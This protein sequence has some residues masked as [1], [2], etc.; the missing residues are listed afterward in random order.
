M[1]IL[2]IR[3]HNIAS[4]ADEFHL[5]LESG[6]LGAAGLFA[7]TGPTGS[8][9]STLLD[10]MCLA[11]YDKTPRFSESGGALVGTHGQD[12][13]LR[14]KAND[15]RTMLRR[16]S[17]SG[18]AEVEFTG[19]DQG[20]Y[21]AR[22]EVRRARD[23]AQG[24]L[25]PQSMT[26]E[27]V[28]TGELVSGNRSAVRASIEEKIGLTFGQFRRSVMLA[29]GD[30]AAFLKAKSGQ[31]AALLE[32]MTGTSIYSHL[33]QK[34]Y[35]RCK[36]EGGI[37]AE[38]N[39]KLHAL[40]IKT[41]EE[42]EQLAGRLAELEEELKSLRKS[43]EGLEETLRWYE[44][45]VR[46]Q[47]EVEEGTASLADAAAAFE[48]A[49]P[50]REE[51]A[52]IEA[53]QPLRPRLDT[54]GE[55]E[56]ATESALTRLDTAQHALEKCRRMADQ[57]EAR[58][59][60]SRAAGQEVRRERDDS[61]PELD[62]AKSLDTRLEESQSR[63]DEANEAADGT[64]E[65]WKQA[66]RLSAEL[67]ARVDAAETG[68]TEARRWLEEQASLDKVAR[69]WEPCEK[70]L[71]QYERA[72]AAHLAAQSDLLRL[73]KT[74]GATEKELDA[75]RARLVSAQAG[76]E[77]LDRAVT[78][79]EA[80]AGQVSGSEL[81]E[82]RRQLEVVRQS[83][84]RAVAAAKAAQE[85]TASLAESNGRREQA[86]ADIEE[87]RERAEA[88]GKSR[89]ELDLRIEEVERAL[90]HAEQAQS[91]EERRADLEEG[92][93]CPLCGSKEHPWAA[94]S[95]LVRHLEDERMRLAG[96]K[97]DHDET[98]EEQAAA[99][100]RIESA[101]TVVSTEEDS[102]KRRCR[103]LVEGE[104][105]WKEALGELGEQN[106][107]GLPKEAAAPSA[108]ERGEALLSESGRRL[109]E[110]DEAE[111][112]WQARQDT[113][114]KAR[115]ER[116]AAR[117][118]HRTFELAVRDAEKKCRQCSDDISARSAQVEQHAAA[119]QAALEGLAPILSAVEDWEVRLQ[120]GDPAALTAALRAEVETYR[121]RVAEKQES[122]EALAALRPELERAR[123]HAEL[124]LAER[125]RTKQT[126]SGLSKK[127]NELCEER[128]RLLGGRA[129]DEYES[130]LQER[131][132]RAEQALEKDRKAVRDAR[133]ELAAADSA[134]KVNERELRNREEEF[135][136]AVAALES[137][138]SELGIT[139]ES[140]RERLEKT[141]EWIDSEKEALVLLDEAGKRAEAVLAERRHQ[142]E[143]HMAAEAPQLAREEAEEQKREIEG[144][145]E[146]LD[147]EVQALRLDLRK[148]DDAR[149]QAARLENE[150]G[151]QEGV[152]KVWAELDTLIGSADGKRFREFAQGLTLDALL[153]HAN[154]HLEELARRYRVQRVPGYDLDLQV[155]DRDMGDEAR[156]INSLSGGETFLV[157]LALALGLASLSSSETPV[158]SLFIDEGFGTL[159]RETLETALSALDGLQASG[160]KVGIISHVQGLAEHIGIQVR[161]E[162]VGAG[163]SVVEVYSA[164]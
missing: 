156:S 72:K 144:E 105:Q 114:R 5:E 33:S 150:I 89:K 133:E 66:E 23:R 54:V 65:S 103:E 115:E 140:L 31:R 22:W 64:R 24:R 56:A 32:R 152:A 16:G 69:H 80:E 126:L 127:R 95:P 102:S 134:V 67:L 94:G 147:E 2:S 15:V 46:L 143:S 88:A 42:R 151:E 7:I 90:A 29:Q 98:V 142:L 154:R 50:R 162:K 104:E 52:R 135:Q 77:E 1:K 99:R 116:E 63:V 118:E 123:T 71:D 159:D 62:R 112:E 17:G 76:L 136:K 27:N 75:Q 57:A 131:F 164:C 28:R 97:A 122:E 121:S 38:L 110:Q 47:Q 100:A 85:R 9:K 30:F 39:G 148:D 157:S 12:E 138:I 6:P 70:L 92:R 130:D 124:A 13:A 109:D 53:V 141:P 113:A 73:E 55:A 81:S 146:Q 10:C 93:E 61:G 106:R 36:A 91:M 119:R 68:L 58:F 139:I 129:V 82:R 20:H 74:L 111:K 120:Q 149:A 153:H 125:D 25:R 43:K 35:G 155:I 45:Q 108:L 145:L 78:S 96:L 84:D 60:Q 37:L 48:Q 41:G 107:A 79:S 26:L 18:W 11:L 87:A 163:K 117:E 160:R 3:G 40:G 86:L 101:Q 137:A 161:V 4:L 49:G 8:G 34:A 51:L 132:E 14:L 158:E 44:R 19:V 128:K 59:V 21:R 83:A